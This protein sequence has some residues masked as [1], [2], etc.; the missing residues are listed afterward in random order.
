MFILH[1]LGLFQY[2]LACI[3]FAAP[4]DTEGG[5]QF[6]RSAFAFHSKIQD[7]EIFVSHAVSESSEK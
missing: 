4:T 6:E 5:H 2:R 3:L 1:V 7:I